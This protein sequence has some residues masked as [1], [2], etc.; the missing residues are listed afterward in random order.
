MPAAINASTMPHLVNWVNAIADRPAVR[1]A[2]AYSRN[3][4]RRLD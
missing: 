2:L 3:S 4:L 1:S